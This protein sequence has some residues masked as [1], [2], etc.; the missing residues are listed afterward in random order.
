MEELKKVV[1]VT[2]SDFTM[3]IGDSLTGND[4]V[5]QA[6]KYDE[7][8]GVDGIILAKADIDEKGGATI[9]TSYVI[10]KPILY[11]GTGQGYDD[12]EEF[13]IEKVMDKLGL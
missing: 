7:L 8:I 9:S 12:L 2:K 6:E 10:N 1:R 11:L 5:E 4:A 3:F 13:D